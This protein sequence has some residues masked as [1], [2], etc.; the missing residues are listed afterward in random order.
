[1]R[2]IAEEA[3]EVARKRQQALEE[4]NT[5]SKKPKPEEEKPKNPWILPLKWKN[6]VTIGLK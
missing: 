3:A 2:Q 4:E 6:Q 1:M 5:K